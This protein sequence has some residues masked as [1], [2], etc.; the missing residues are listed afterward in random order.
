MINIPIGIVASVLTI[1]FI[2]KK[3]GEGKNKE[4]TYIDYTGIALLMAALVVCNM[5]WKE[6]AEDWFSSNSIRICKS[7]QYWVDRIYCL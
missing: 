2:D 3:P 6:E 1:M 7:L 5:F 4:S